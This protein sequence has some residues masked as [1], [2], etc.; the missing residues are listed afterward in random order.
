MTSFKLAKVE[1]S[2]WCD[3]KFYVWY[4]QRYRGQS[5]FRPILKKLLVSVDRAIVRH[6]NDSDFPDRSFDGGY[7]LL[8]IAT[9]LIF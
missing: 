3:S 8:P 5:A 9:E 6:P 7:I 2:F 4:E 1:L